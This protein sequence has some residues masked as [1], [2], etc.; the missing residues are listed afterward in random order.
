MAAE[1][2]QPLTAPSA[3]AWSLA[4]RLWPLTS[5][6]LWEASVKLLPGQALTRRFMLTLHPPRRPRASAAL[7]RLLLELGLP[8]AFAQDLKARLGAAC[9]LHVAIE[10]EGPRTLHKLYLEL[11]QSAR[12]TAADAANGDAGRLVH[13]A[14]KWDPQHPARRSIAQYRDWSAADTATLCARIDSLLPGASPPADLLRDAAR[15]LVSR[16]AQR[17]S[18]AELMLLAVTEGGNQRRSFDLGLYDAELPVGALRTP[19]LGLARGFDLPT[20]AAAALLDALADTPL[21]HFAGGIAR[22]GRPFC[23]LFY[24]A[25]RLAPPAAAGGR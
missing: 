15:T 9:S 7:G 2:I 8:A 14:Y 19:L 5:V 25:G 3:E 21:G 11:P 16:A 17:L 22:D 1:P 12:S 23:T 6:L 10:G 13:L 18:A 24:G 20:G 4:E